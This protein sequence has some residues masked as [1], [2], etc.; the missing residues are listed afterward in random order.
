[1]RMNMKRGGCAVATNPWSEP[2]VWLMSM[3][4]VGIVMLAW[5]WFD[6]DARR[7]LDRCRARWR[8]RRVAA[9]EGQREDHALKRAKFFSE[10]EMR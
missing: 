7:M 6:I 5:Y 1:M 2:I 8:R 4:C 10:R 3:A 9:W